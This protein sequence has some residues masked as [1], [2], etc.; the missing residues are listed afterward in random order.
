MKRKLSLSFLGAL[1]MLLVCISCSKD[2]EEEL[3]SD[4]DLNTIDYFKEI[5][6][7]FEF[8]NASEVTRKWDSDMK[9]FIGGNPS[10][11]LLAELDA[12][13]N[14]INMLATD[15]FQLTV[16]NDSTQSNFYV[17]FGTGNDYS[18]IFPSQTNLVEGNLGLFSIFWDNTNFFTY[19]H[20][21]VDTERADPMAQKHL[22]REELTQSLGLAKDSSLYPLSIFQ[23]EWTT[24]NSYTPIDRAI[25]QLLYHPDMRPGLDATAVDPILRDILSNN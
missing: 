18:A 14:E 23:S 15:G 9:L 7:G 5:A 11:E 19:G 6:L 12:V 13:K 2:T 25:I 3:L 24:T 8:G 4:I 16:V 22:L 17:F 20:M 21:Y 1:C 10:Q